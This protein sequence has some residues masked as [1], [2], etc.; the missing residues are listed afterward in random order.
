VPG[1]PGPLAAAKKHKTSKGKQG[2]VHAPT[3]V[4]ASTST[5][6]TS[7]ALSFKLATVV[8]ETTPALLKNAPVYVQSTWCSDFQPALYEAMF[9]SSSP[10]TLENDLQG[11]DT[12]D[13]VQQV[14][15]RVHPGRI[16]D[17]NRK[18]AIFLTVRHADSL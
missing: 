13:C 16:L 1:E 8:L 9:C 5:S 2:A 11:T 12:K 7:S 6:S 10:F 17:I 18:D 14:F 3:L 4:Q 15:N